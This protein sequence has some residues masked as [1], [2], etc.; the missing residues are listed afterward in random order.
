LSNA[1]GQE[2]NEGLEA[3]NG[4]GRIGHL[5]GYEVR[6]S[7][8][9]LPKEGWIGDEFPGVGR[10]LGFN[11]GGIQ[12]IVEFIGRFESGKENGGESRIES[13]IE[14]WLNLRHLCIAGPIGFAVSRGGGAAE[15][16]AVRQYAEGGSLAELLARPP[17]RWTA[18]AKA[19]AVVGLAPG[20]RFTNGVG[21][22]HGRVRPNCVLF[23]GAGAIQIA[24]IGAVRSGGD[25]EFMAPEIE[26][27]G[28]RLRRRTFFRLRG[29]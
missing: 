21:R 6:V 13:E 9:D 4:E 7:Q 1:L 27:G 5:E 17:P 29:L 10:G 22:P 11:S 24:G 25:A 15:L 16:R 14:T 28:A 19:I 18:T 2:P 12:F 26:S 23:D 8:R 20:L 3:L